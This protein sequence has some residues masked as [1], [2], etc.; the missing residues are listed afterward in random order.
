MAGRFDTI[1]RICQLAEERNIPLSRLAKQCGINPSTLN[2]CKNRGGQ[3]RL[4]TINKLCNGMGIT[5][6]EFFTVPALQ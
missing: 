5:L 6:H 2:S 4:G 3:L 1:G